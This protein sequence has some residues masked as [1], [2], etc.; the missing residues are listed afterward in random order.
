MMQCDICFRTGGRKL[1]FLCPTDARNQLY[2]ARIQNAQVLLEQDTLKQEIATLLSS[3]P[4]SDKA[5]K[6][7]TLPSRLESDEAVSERAQAIDRTQQIIAHADELQVKLDKAREEI[8]KKKDIL[9]RRRSELASATNG[10][11][12]RRARQNDEVER[13]IRMIKYKW[14]NIHSVT[15]TS[16]AFLC[17]EAA[18]LYGL[19]KIRR[20]SDGSEEY[21][22]GGISIV[23]LRA[24]NCESP[25][26]V[27]L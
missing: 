4:H 25:L 13:A 23:D 11:E 7:Q 14:N 16:R 3:Y 21:R 24:M 1:P 26:F 17:G 15:A 5:T 8:A 10:V 2:E 9:A 22:I 12:A 19:R 18:R 6:A 27:I 20:T